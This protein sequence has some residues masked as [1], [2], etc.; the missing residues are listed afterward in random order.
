[1]KFKEAYDD[2]E[3]YS[4]ILKK[5][6]EKALK[7]KIRMPYHFHPFQ[8]TIWLERMFYLNK[9]GNLEKELWKKHGAILTNK[10]KEYEMMR[11]RKINKRLD[12]LMENE[13]FFSVHKKEL[14]DMNKHET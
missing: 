14:E 3:K 12:E 5:E 10:W 8:N 2:I 6:L 1:M 9:L 7:I 11:M 4:E 13:K